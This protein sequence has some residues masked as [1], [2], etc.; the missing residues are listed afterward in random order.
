MPPR[1]QPTQEDINASWGTF[2]RPFA[3]GLSLDAQLPI[4]THM[5]IKGFIPNL[6]GATEVKAIDRAGRAIQSDS[7]HDR[8]ANGQ[9]TYQGQQQE[10]HEPMTEEQ[11]EKSMDHL[12][13]LPSLKEHKWTVHLEELPEGRF[14]FVMDNLGNLVRKIPESD[15]WSLPSDD[16]PRGQLLKRSA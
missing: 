15:L 6:I 3:S 14:V 11:L 7:T 13:S 4:R 16:S 9:E 1:Y 8:D 12:R 10:Q 5:N 2:P